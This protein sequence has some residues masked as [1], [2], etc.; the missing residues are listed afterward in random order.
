VRLFLPRIRKVLLGVFLAETP[1]PQG[2]LAAACLVPLRRTPLGIG[3]VALLWALSLGQA[4]VAGTLAEHKGSPPPDNSV[5]TA[6]TGRTQSGTPTNATRHGAGSTLRPHKRS[7][8][9]PRISRDDD[10]QDD[11]TSDD[12]NDDVIWDD[13]N[14]DDDPG[15]PVIAVPH[16]TVPDLLPTGRA[17][18]TRPALPSSP[19]RTLERLRC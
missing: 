5:Q 6:A 16:E 14:D 19:L 7:H 12:P 2:D 11:E 3:V 4:S 17:P 15:M 13:P 8:A 9:F 1:A 18:V 10:S